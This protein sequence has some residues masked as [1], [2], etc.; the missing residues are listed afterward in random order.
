MSTNMNHTLELNRI[1]VRLISP[2]YL[3]WRYHFTKPN[4]LHHMCCSLWTTAVLYEWTCNSFGFMTTMQT[5]PFA[6]QAAPKYFLKDICNLAPISST[7]SSAR[8]LHSAIRNGKCCSKPF[9]LFIN[10]FPARTQDSQKFPAEFMALCAPTVFNAHT[11]WKKAHCLH[12]Q[13]NLA[14]C[15][16]SNAEMSQQVGLV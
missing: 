8:L 16:A 1:K 12:H 5:Y 6:V 14:M 13:R 9:H 15:P 3:F 2:A 7:F 11:T 4:L 10:C